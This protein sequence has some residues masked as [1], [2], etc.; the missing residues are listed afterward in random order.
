MR[1]KYKLFWAGLMLAVFFT[2]LVPNPLL[3]EKPAISLEQAIQTAKQLFPI[4]ATYNDFHSEFNK[5]MQGESWILRWQAQEPESGSLEVTI[6]AGNGECINMYYWRPD[7]ADGKKQSSLS[8]AEAQKVAE[9]YLQRLLPQKVSSLRLLKEQNI[10]PLNDN[11][12]RNYSFFW[13]R[14]ENGVPVLGD[15][16]RIEIDGYN[17]DIRSYNLNWLDTSLQSTSKT[18]TEKQAL[19]VFQ[20]EQMLKLEYY[21]PS[22]VRPLDNKQKDNLCLVYLINHPSN[23]TIN[24]IT[25][26]PMILKNGQWEEN[27]RNSYDSAIKEA[28]AGGMGAGSAPSLSPEELKE[29]EKNS[30]IISQD[31][32]IK[33]VK[34]WV[35]IPDGAILTNS[36]LGRDWQNPERRIWNLNWNK[37]R[38]DNESYENYSL[39]ARVDAFN[40]RIYSFYQYSD[41]EPPKSKMDRDKAALIADSFIKQIEPQLFGQLKRE[42][43]SSDP[44]AILREENPAQWRFVY[45]RM[46]GNIPFPR[47]G[48]EITVSTSDQ[49]VTNYNLNWSEHKFPDANR[50]ISIQEGYKAFLETAPLTLCYSKIYQDN[51]KPELVLVYKPTPS[52]EQKNFSMLDAISGELLDGSGRPVAEKVGPHVFKDISGHFAEKQINMVGQAG[53]MNE[54]GQQFHPDEAVNTGTF[55]RTLLGA[56]DGVWILDGLDDVRLLKYCQDRGWIKEKIDISTPLSRDYMTQVMVRSMD[57]ERVAKNASLFVNPYPNDPSVNNSN[58]GYVALARG[59]GLLPD[60][61]AFNGTETVTRGEIAYAIVNSL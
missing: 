23:G 51:S 52:L 10:I 40:G 54:Y 35:A 9:G 61:P 50:A 20:D 57:L 12:Q 1:G 46:I 4:P 47:E 42:N 53:L 18:I 8:E 49:K 34:K 5:H 59:M 2:T 30:Q 14:Y 36:S 3:A 60:I 29:L 48:I 32:A 26:K 11:G 56:R 13:E 15:G 58:L 17:R 28:G 31:E 22:T 6:N 55:L 27:M 24:A 45:S 43:D 25:G 33:R 21:A 38:T 41:Q 16:V 19:K 37:P 7:K 44:V 39:Y